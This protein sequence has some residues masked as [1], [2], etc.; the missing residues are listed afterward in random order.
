L[1][2]LVVNFINVLQAAFMHTDPKKYS[3]AVSLFA[4]LR[5]GIVK[6]ASKMLS[7]S[8]PGVNFTNVLRT[9]FTLVDP[10]SL[11]I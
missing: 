7:K 8:T 9:A 4:L 1:L 11:K 10:K 6:A 5:S 3:Q 2:L